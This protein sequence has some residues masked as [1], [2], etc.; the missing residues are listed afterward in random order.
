MSRNSTH[1]A[2]APARTAA[3]PFILVTVLMDMITIGLILPILPA[4]VGTFTSTP[5]ENALWY[6]VL[7]FSFGFSNFIFA[8][9]LGGLSDSYGR[10][11]VLLLG[12]FGVVV[13]LLCSGLANS[14][15][16]LVLARLFC[17]AMQANLAVANAYVA[18][19]TPPSEL[20]KRFGHIG[21]MMGIGFVLGPA[22]GGGAGHI[23]LRLP[24]YIASGLAALNWLYGYFV[25]PESLP[26]ERRKPFAW[27]RVGLTGGMSKMFGFG[28]AKPLIAV[29]FV[30]AVAQITFNAT[31]VLYTHDRF[32]W[33]PRESGW[34]MFAIGML[35][36]LA[37]GVLVNLLGRRIATAR[38]AIIGLASAACAYVLFGLNGS[39]WLMFPIMLV[40]GAGFASAAAVQSQIVQDLAGVDQ[41]RL[42]GAVT[43]V[44]ALA[45]L[46]AP[47]LASG[48]LTL[49][50]GL[51]ADDWRIG[52]P[53]F[54]CAAI[55]GIAVI[56]AL[57]YFKRRD[58]KAFNRRASVT[59][60][61]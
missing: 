23:D 36:L 55:Q 5:Q 56:I 13:S 41:G 4:W 18:D 22:I 44:N 53:M 12:I 1:K 3:M 51:P 28:S 47:L 21:A 7:V 15:G 11:P 49:I 52:M 34:S 24:F 39:L 57:I 31:W 35:T 38:L 30:T 37:Q 50:A 59:K 20:T 43:S 29:L 42:F 48:A 26:P 60:T 8:P 46:L 19:I 6:G 9:Q 25:L 27:R 16:M 14:L 45:T 61:S 54:A 2:A 58:R 33:G 10:R 32:A 17:G 40:H